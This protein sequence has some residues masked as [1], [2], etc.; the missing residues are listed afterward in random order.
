M[1]NTIQKCAVFPAPCAADEGICTLPNVL[2]DEQAK[3]TPGGGVSRPFLWL[4]V[5]GA[6]VTLLH[7]HANAEDLRGI[8]GWLSE[9]SR[10]LCANILA[11]EYPGYGL[12]QVPHIIEDLES[13]GDVIRAIDSAAVHALMYLVCS[14]C[15]PSE[16]IVLH[17][18]SIGNGPALR[19]A[20]YARDWL[21]LDLGGIVLQSPSLSVQQV[22]ADWAG[23]AGQ[24]LMPAYYD[25]MAV[26][27][28]LCGPLQGRGV[29]RWIPTLLIHGEKDDVI[30]PYHAHSLHCEAVKM[31]HPAVELWL[32]THA[33]HQEWDIHKDVVHPI[34]SFVSRHVLGTGD[35]GSLHGYY[36]VPVLKGFAYHREESLPSLSFMGD[37]DGSEPSLDGSWNEEQF[38][39][40]RIPDG[41][42]DTPCLDDC[43]KVA[44]GQG[45]RVS[46]C[47]RH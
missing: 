15:I 45:I 2:W 38:R 9:L 7:F 4:E 42:E 37:S 14:R 32:A 39:S 24:L 28:M 23:H 13:V 25:N 6:E 33:T 12:L 35:C 30:E 19:L 8:S 36:D 10:C 41:L 20:R 40:R 11:I 44:P 34:S 47:S 46:F 17:G 29:R 18:R 43:W 26:L 16:K 27:R 1:G 21:Q 5:P 22:A 31:G 3:G